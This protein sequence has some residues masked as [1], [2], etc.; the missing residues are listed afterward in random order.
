MR[1][2]RIAGALALLVL[3]GCCCTPCRQVCCPATTQTAPTPPVPPTPAKQVFVELADDGWSEPEDEMDP[4]LPRFTPATAAGGGSPVNARFRGTDRKAAKTS[5]ASA[6]VETFSTLKLFIDSLP[7]DDD[8][9][10]H[11]PKIPK[12]ATSDR[13][14][15]EE[16]NVTVVAWIHAIKYEADQDWHIIAGSSA[17][18][19]TATFFNCEVSGLPPSSSPHRAQLLAAR[20]GLDVVLDHNLPIAETYRKFSPAIKVRITGSIFFDIDHKAGV[21]GPTGMR[22]KTA[23]E[24]HPVTEIARVP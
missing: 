4:T 16:R 5:I 1:A 8:M 3:A 14:S 6:P 12:S 9:I 18:A 22:P 11:Q 24:I 21:V 13:V 23:W 15:G 19:A 2:D 7:S 10:D 17:N 20:K